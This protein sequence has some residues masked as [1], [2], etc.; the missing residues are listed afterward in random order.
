MAIF[1][2]SMQ[3]NWEMDM[4]PVKSLKGVVGSMGSALMRSFLMGKL[5]P[6]FKTK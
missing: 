4:Q 5:I 2:V 3:K 1:T 6:R